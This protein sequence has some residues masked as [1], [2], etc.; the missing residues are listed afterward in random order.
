[1]VKQILIFA[2]LASSM[3]DCD[4]V[5][6]FPAGT[7]T[8]YR[9]VYEDSEEA[10]IKLLAPT[11]I[12]NRGKI[13]VYNNYLLIVDQGKG[14]HIIDNANPVLPIKKGFISIIGSEDVAIKDGVMFASY[15]GGLATI[16]L[17]NFSNVKMLDMIIIDNE[18][19]SSN[20]PP[21]EGY[22]FECPDPIR[23]KVLGWVKE[24]LEN[25]KC[26]TPNSDN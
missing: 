11:E 18:L 25:P 10:K 4:P 5:P 2:I 21:Y 3:N 13:Y 17:S 24:R 22:Y 19:Q 16:D 26:G 15:I 7:V 14:I 6:V 12:T 23:G 9:P 8:G 1:M 20:V